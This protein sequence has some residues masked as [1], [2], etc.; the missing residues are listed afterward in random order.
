MQTNSDQR[1]SGS[2]SGSSFIAM[3]LTNLARGPLKRAFIETSHTYQ[4]GGQPLAPPALQG[5]RRKHSATAPHHPS[6]AT[7][8]RQAQSNSSCRAP[9]PALSLGHPCRAPDS[10]G[11]ARSKEGGL[12]KRRRGLDHGSALKLHS[13]PWSEIPTVTLVLEAT[14]TQ[15]SEPP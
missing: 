15:I 5:Q 9:L 13:L 3:H 10:R 11:L 2:L 12:G 1:R 4:G 7:G 6:R 14:A 8:N